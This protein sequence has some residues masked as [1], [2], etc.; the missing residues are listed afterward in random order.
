MGFGCALLAGLA[1]AALGA[2]VV[3]ALA[4]MMDMVVLFLAWPLYSVALALC[5]LVSAFL[6]AV[7]TA[8]SRGGSWG[9]AMLIGGFGAISGFTAILLFMAM[10]NQ[11]IGRW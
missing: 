2:G 11:G 7:A 5:A 10:T 4:A 1:G 9:A 6:A 3:L 8:F